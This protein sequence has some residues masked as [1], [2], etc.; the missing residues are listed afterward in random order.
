[1]LIYLHGFRSSPA[2]VKSQHLRTR[3][4]E[5]GLQ[6]RLWSESLP[7]EPRLAIEKIESAIRV[8]AKPPLLVGSSLGG[9][10]ATYLAQTHGLDAVLINPAADA[11]SLLK[12]WVGPHENLYTG[13]P[14]NLTDAHIEQLEGL[15]I[16]S[17]SHPERFWLLV[18]T[19]DEILD[20]RQAVR[21]YQGARQT[22]IPGGD[23]GLQSFGDYVDEIID[24][25]IAE[26]RTN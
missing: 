10:Y 7:V 17:L 12:P 14:F 5:R 8:A 3:M 13:E 22:V 11:A 19:G 21:R 26:A 9:Y 6:D 25:A 20:Y 18:E 16:P 24:L 23:H 4:A 2:S 1:M 15:W